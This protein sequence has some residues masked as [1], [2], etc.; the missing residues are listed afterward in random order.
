MMGEVIFA[1]PRTYYGSYADMYRLIEL[2]GFPTV[3]FDEID[4]ASDN[5]YIM[6]V[7]NG[8]NQAGW[9][10]PRAKIVLW[11]F[12]WRPDGRPEIPGV[13]EYWHMDA[14]AAR[15]NGSRYVP[16]GGHSGLRDEMPVGDDA[17]RYDLAYLGYMVNRR[18]AVAVELDEIGVKRTVTSAW[19]EERHQAL[20]KSTAYL[21]VHQ[22]GNAPGVPALRMV[23]AAAYR[24]PVIAE[25]F[26]DPGVFDGLTLQSTYPH[27]ASFAK[28]WAMEPCP[29]LNDYAVRLHRLL[30]HDLTFRR[31]VE[32]SL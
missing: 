6:T 15:H 21:H 16:V 7:S 23:V 9:Q 13:A 3:H 8:E 29:I 2:S 14:W 31:S 19:G 18:Q 28:M 26:A 25:T 12:E 17:P 27:I 20:S 24:L 32:M 10:Q 30:C 1:V 4:P 22:L 5:C 11:D